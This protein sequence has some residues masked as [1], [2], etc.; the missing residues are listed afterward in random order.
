MTDLDAMRQFAEVKWNGHVYKLRQLAVSEKGIVK[1]LQGVTNENSLE[2]AKEILEFLCA[3]FKET[4]D[5]FDEKKFKGT[6]T[7]AMINETM[8]VLMKGDKSNAG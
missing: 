6:L 8:R 3:R 7:F 5:P 1:R 4:G 2:V